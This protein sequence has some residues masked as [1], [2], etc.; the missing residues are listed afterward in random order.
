MKNCIYEFSYK[1]TQMR[2]SVVQFCG[3]SRCA[4]SSQL[5]LLKLIRNFETQQSFVRECLVIIRKQKKKEIYV[6][7]E[8]VGNP[9]SLLL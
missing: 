1:F 3:T 4:Y 9:N 8:S 5:N 6:Y 7:N 2:C